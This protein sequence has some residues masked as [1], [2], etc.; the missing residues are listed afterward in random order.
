MLDLGSKVQNF[1]SSSY[2]GELDALIWACKCTKAFRGMI[3][4]VVCTDNHALVEKWRSGTFYDLDIRIFRRWVWL[5]ANEPKLRLEY[6]PRTENVGADLLSRPR[7]GR[8]KNIEDRDPWVNQ[9]S[10]WD[11]IWAE[12]M[13]GHWGVFKTYKA[14]QSR[15]SATTWAMVRRVCELC[16][17]CAKF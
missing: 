14:L 13:K 2:L 1:A 3:P 12:H 15:G 17:V 6:V 8:L 16:E 11:E 4:T 7:L 5:L 9:V 10:I